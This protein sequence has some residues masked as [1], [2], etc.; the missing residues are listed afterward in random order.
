ML[1]AHGSITKMNIYSL[2]SEAAAS[3][4]P[5][6]PFDLMPLLLINHDNLVENPSKQRLASTTQLQILV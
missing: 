2:E 3:A 5:D 1:P 4:F 6:G